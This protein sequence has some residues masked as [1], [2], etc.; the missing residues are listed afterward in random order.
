MRSERVL[1]AAGAVY[2]LAMV[3]GNALTQGGN[4]AG[5]S[6]AALAA[7]R[8]GRSTAQSAGA[9]L[10]ALS[11]FALLAFLAHL[12]RVLRTAERPAARAATAAFG[13]GLVMT[14]VDV[15]SAMP[16]VAAYLG[17][18]ELTPPLLGT[19]HALNDAGFVISGYLYGIFIAL[20][21]ASAFG[22]R[23]LPRWLAG[24][25][26]A[27]GVLAVVAGLAGLVD[28]TGYVPVPFLLCLA[29]VL[30]TSLLLA[31]RGPRVRV[32]RDGDAAKGVPA[33]LR[34]TA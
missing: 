12:Y 3:A 6:S 15:A 30:L 22:S 18:D 4:D 1:A 34:A 9:V 24:S 13:A 19:L 10:G 32:D 16:S 28:P 11:A 5:N 8:Q 29:W 21:A 20:A 2:V 14:A 25:G 7:L 23:V 33:E 26:L 27:I 17:R 31:V